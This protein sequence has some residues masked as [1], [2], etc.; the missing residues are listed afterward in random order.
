MWRIS[1]LV[2]QL[3]SEETQ[4]KTA[5][6]SCSYNPK[7]SSCLCVSCAKPGFGFLMTWLFLLLST[8][9]VL[10]PRLPPHAVFHSFMFVLLLSLFPQD[11]MASV[12]IFEIFYS[13]LER[14]PSRL[15]EHKGIGSRESDLGV[16]E[17]FRLR[18][19]AIG[20]RI[21]ELCSFHAVLSRS[22]GTEKRRVPTTKAH[23]KSVRSFSDGMIQHGGSFAS[24]FQILYSLLPA[25]TVVLFH[26]LG[27]WSHAL[28]NQ[29]EQRWHEVRDFPRTAM[30][31]CYSPDFKSFSQ[32]VSWGVGASTF[33]DAMK[34][35]GWDLW[36]FRSLK[37]LSMTPVCMTLMT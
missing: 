11:F 30:L 8:G 32:V 26:P 23:L 35:A 6:Q 33:F 14:T 13:G 18:L 15:V 2:Q 34:C 21:N 12:I 28:G 27:W 29:P 4:S 3:P 31:Q 10:T 17:S 25:S 9:W 7:H 22:L 1:V 19:Q 24:T 20:R 16:S 5:Q 36:P 37:Q